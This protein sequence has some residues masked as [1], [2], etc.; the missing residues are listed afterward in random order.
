VLLRR[1]FFD[2]KLLNIDQD[3]FPSPRQVGIET[4]TRMM[5]SAAFGCA[6]FSCHQKELWTIVLR[7]EASS[8]ELC[9]CA[10]RWRSVS[11]PAVV[12][13]IQTTNEAAIVLFSHVFIISLTRVCIN[14]RNNSSVSCSITSA[15]V[16]DQKGCV[17]LNGTDLRWLSPSLL[18]S[19][20][21]F[22]KA[23]IPPYPS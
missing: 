14:T 18:A 8:T 5:S 15:A 11:E 1:H 9:N 22:Q 7:D 16:S 13:E 21:Q 23:G 12:G 6:H 20:E 4:G 10:Q 3:M 2:C 19:K 17:H